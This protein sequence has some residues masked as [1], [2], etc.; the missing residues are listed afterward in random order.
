M[1]QVINAINL[2]STATGVVASFNYQTQRLQ[3]NDVQNQ[4]FL[5]S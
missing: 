4:N 2:A 3:L 1:A 5:I